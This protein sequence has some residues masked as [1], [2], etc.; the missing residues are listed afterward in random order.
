MVL[1]DVAVGVCCRGETP[2]V[3]RS[4][5]KENHLETGRPKGFPSFFGG[6]LTSKKAAVKK[7]I[8]QVPEGVLGPA[9]VQKTHTHPWI[10]HTNN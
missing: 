8:S 3:F 9:S 5:K 1:A 2:P 6:V 7:R 4:S 10:P